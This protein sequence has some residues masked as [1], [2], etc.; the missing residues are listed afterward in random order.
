MLKHHNDANLG[1]IAEFCT[2][3][4]HV[5]GHEG[6]CL[7]SCDCLIGR[8]NVKI[9][10]PKTAVALVKF[11]RK[12]GEYFLRTYTNCY[13]NKQ[14]AEEHF[15]SDV[16]ANIHDFGELKKVTMYITMQPCHKSVSDT[17]GTKENW[18]CCDTLID[19]VKKDEERCRLKDVEIVIKPTHLS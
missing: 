16:E 4:Y 14:H 13:S 8:K 1:S 19:L 3:F 5:P 18:S 11:E 7:D 2:A 10:Q 9:K 12:N 17:G 15:K 6:V